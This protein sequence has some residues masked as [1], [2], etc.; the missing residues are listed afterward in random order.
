MLPPFLAL[1]LFPSLP[2]PVISIL[3]V[4]GNQPDN[5]IEIP[6]LLTGNQART[7]YHYTN[8]KVVTL[9]MRKD[10]RAGHLVRRR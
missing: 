10:R 7:L 4:P 9:F 3:P 2:V 6:R 5:L 8:V 1:Y